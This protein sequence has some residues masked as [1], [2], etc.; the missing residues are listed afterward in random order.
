MSAGG[1][2][3]TQADREVAYGI[4]QASDSLTLRD[5][6]L[7]VQAFARHRIAHQQPLPP[8][9]VDALRE[10]REALSRIEAAT[11]SDAR[12]GDKGYISRNGLQGIANKAL[13]RLTALLDGTDAGE[14]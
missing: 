12:A 11:R 4:W 2:E 1:V 13:A 10:A 6:K 5:A 9:V 3:V 14:G 8:A 7:L